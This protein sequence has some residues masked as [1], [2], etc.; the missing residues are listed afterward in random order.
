MLG[1]IA[2]FDA[3]HSSPWVLWDFLIFEGRIMPAAEGDNLV[4]AGSGGIAI[5]SCRAH[6]I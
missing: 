1:G 4:L 3:G 5:A 6:A 2:V